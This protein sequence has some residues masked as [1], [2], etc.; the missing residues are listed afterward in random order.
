MT[1]IDVLSGKDD[2]EKLEN[3][4]VVLVDVEG[5][6]TPGGR[7]VPKNPRPEHVY[8][9]FEG[10]TFEVKT[11][12]GYWSGL[13]LLAGERPS[14]YFQRVDKWWNG[15]IT[16]EEFE[17]KNVNQLNQLLD[18]SDHETAQDL[19]EWYNR[20][21][22]NLREKSPELVKAFHSEE[23]SVGVLSHTSESLSITAAEQLDAD[24]VV[25]SWTFQF[26][27]GRFEFIE[28]EIYADDKSEVVDEMKEAGVE[29]IYFVG[30]G[31]NDIDICERADQAFMIENKEQINYEQL[32]AD[33]GEFKEVVKKVRER[34]G[35]NN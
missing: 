33:S 23:F 2:F 13:H 18:R 21:F 28:K 12:L 20:S 32:D 1:E 27:E 25:P 11:D 6:V 9:V 26:E 24:F 5:T 14:E 34:L 22:L 4:K 7:H 30:N 8:Q 3:E 16:R 29:E 31:E 17:E 35:G 10:E 15:Q 19:V